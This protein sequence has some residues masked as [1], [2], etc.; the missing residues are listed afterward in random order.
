[1]SAIKFVSYVCCNDSKFRNKNI[2]DQM[3]DMM[4]KYADHLEDL[5]TERTRLLYEEKKKTEDLLHR[6]LPE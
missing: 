2:M 5:V 1:M 6:M 4:V 3:M